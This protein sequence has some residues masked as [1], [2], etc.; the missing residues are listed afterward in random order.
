MCLK[1][2]F[3]FECLKKEGS[4]TFS[5]FW[6]DTLLDPPMHDAQRVYSQEDI[7]VSSKNDDL[8]GKYAVGQL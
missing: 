8:V 2:E 5:G 7:K 1:K 4:Q 3:K 6:H